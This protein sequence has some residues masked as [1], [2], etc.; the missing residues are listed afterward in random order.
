M[1]KKLVY[2]FC[3]LIIAFSACSN[4]LVEAQSKND[5][6]YK[7]NI[8]STRVLEKKQSDITFD[9]QSQVVIAELLE[10]PDKGKSIEVES[11]V[12]VRTGSKDLLKKG[13]KIVV[14]KNP[15]QDS[16]SNYY[17]QGRYRLNHIYAWLVLFVILIISLSKKQGFFSII[18]LFSSVAIFILYILPNIMNGGNVLFTV[19]S[20]IVMAAIISLY[21]AHG[22]NVRTT[23]SL[24]STLI[25]LSFAL[26]CSWVAVKMVHITGSGTEEAY[27]LTFNESLKNI[28]LQGLFLG[29]V[30]IGTLGVL[31]DITT[32]QTAVVAELKR[33]NNHFGWK[34]LYTRSL[35]VGR[36]HIS[37]LVNTLA[38]AY[39]GSSFPV[40]LSYIY[41]VK[42]P[43]WV[44]LN[45]DNIIEQIIQTLVG[46]SALIVAVPISS[47]LAARYF[48]NHIPKESKHIHTHTHN[49]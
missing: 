4:T 17:F 27:L 20:G 25:T 34:E 24:I 9:G 21:I 15:N 39:I 44:I 23:L 1:L 12:Q 43:W 28:N 37:S 48:A 42:V 26:L 6:Y 35:S 33:A 8:I 30:L 2:I 16:K 10:G 47:Y 11:N 3:S 18:G 38:F 46:S 41:A 19:L 13:E 40:L 5:E 14:L 49:H 22:F 45:N 32:A 31:D 7:A 36:E 29:G